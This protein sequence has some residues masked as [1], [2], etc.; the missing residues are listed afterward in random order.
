MAKKLPTIT[1][2]WNEDEDE[3]DIF[4]PTSY[5]PPATSAAATQS[6]ALTDAPIPPAPAPP[7]K[8]APAPAPEPE[9][10]VP[11]FLENTAVGQATSSG[12]APATTGGGSDFWNSITGALTEQTTP[13]P[14]PAPAPT[15]PPAPAPQPPAPQPAPAP[16]P[17]P[18]PAPAPQPTAAWAPASAS[19][20]EDW[21][22]TTDYREDGTYHRRTPIDE[23][24][25]R[26]SVE[27]WIP[28]YGWTGYGLD[29][30]EN[31]ASKSQNIPIGVKWDDADADPNTPGVQVN[32]YTEFN[33]ERVNLDY[34]KLGDT[35]DGGHDFW[36]R[37]DYFAKPDPE[38]AARFP[39]LD[40]YD[41]AT[42]KAALDAYY[43]D[44]FERS[45][46]GMIDQAESDAYYASGAGAWDSR[47]RMLVGG[48]MSEAEATEFMEANDGPRPNYTPGQASPDFTEFDQN[49]QAWQEN[50]DQGGP[51]PDAV[52]RTG[53]EALEYL[54]SIWGPNFDPATTIPN[55]LGTLEQQEEIMRNGGYPEGFLDQLWAD[56]LAGRE[57]T[58]INGDPV[59]GAI[60]N[61]PDPVPGTGGPDRP[62]TDTTTPDSDRPADPDY[63]GPPDWLSDWLQNWSNRGD[64]DSEVPDWLL[65][66]GEGGTGYTPTPFI[67]SE[68]S[69]APPPP[70]PEGPGAAPDFSAAA[71]PDPMTGLYPDLET[72]AREW[73]QNYNPYATGLVEATRAAGDARRQGLLDDGTRR[74]EE[75]A[76]SRGLLGSTPE[77]GWQ[78]ELEGQVRRDLL[79][80][81]A[82]LQN[83]LA[84][85]ELQG[86]QGAFNA[87]LGLTELQ[88]RD[89]I[90]RA[91]LAL[92]AAI[93]GDK[94]A[95]DRARIELDRW[96]A[97]DEATLSREELA[98]RDREIE[99]E[100]YRMQEDFRLRGI[101]LDTDTAIAYAELAIRKQGLDQDRERQRILDGI[102]LME[103]F[104]NAGITMTPEMFESLFGYS[105]PNPAQDAANQAINNAIPEFG[106]VNAIPDRHP[107]TNQ[108]WVTGDRVKIG[109]K[110]YT[111]GADGTWK[112]SA[113]VI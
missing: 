80:E 42:R 102:A 4:D 55:A 32:P 96:R 85:Y 73:M 109:G 21:T 13:A 86:R 48:G 7:T 64:D 16:A 41:Y 98:R 82:R 40:S 44:Q 11:S 30:K 104:D 19:G 74:I 71:T 15:P 65:N 3:E 62:S 38:T 45:R 75:L 60:P 103:Y 67:P 72:F 9:P 28:G 1:E 78:M 51:K 89:S 33:G 47:Y 49:Q 112:Y 43:A 70:M 14:T 10:S 106:A 50:W 27:Y 29:T 83:A 54:R 97:E 76:S 8:P 77:L 87:G 26:N 94:A 105:L 35:K 52:L 69:V 91:E 66:L 46:Q 22:P 34:F 17:Q 63:D 90:Q 110:V 107:A 99:M 68:G 88:Q 20:S 5:Q 36:Y 93:Q 39:G 101:E 113:G 37:E 81:E 108:P 31:Y 53:D 95:L 58:G 24:G 23:Y 92:E 25:Q 84:D 18:A 100:A 111:F 6:T 79:D 56:L 57:T 61:R 2:W 12:G 59:G